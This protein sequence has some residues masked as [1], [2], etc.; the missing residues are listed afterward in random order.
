MLTPS[1]LQGYYGGLRLLL[2]T[3]KVFSNHCVETGLENRVREGFKLSY[4][5]TIP[6]MVRHFLVLC[7]FCVQH[8]LLLCI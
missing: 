8:A 6:R 1:G 5:T 7:H 4:V 3:C 2:A